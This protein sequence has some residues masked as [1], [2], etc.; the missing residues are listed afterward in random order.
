MLKCCYAI[1][2]M[3][4]SK[5]T[6]FMLSLF[7]KWKSQ[8]FSNFSYPGLRK[9]L[10]S[11]KIIISGQKYWRHLLQDSLKYLCAQFGYDWRENKEMVKKVSNGPLPPQTYL[12]SKKPNPCRV[13]I[14]SVQ[15]TPA[16]GSHLESV[17][18]TPAYGSHS[19]SFENCN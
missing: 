17:Q 6:L 4:G 15:S 9:V 18:S 8:K 3:C 14:E 16:Y 2:W 10:T 11:A 19:A 12:T 5:N 7:K 13:T 1:F